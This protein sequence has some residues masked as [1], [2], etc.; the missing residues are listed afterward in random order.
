MV[1]TFGM[2]TTVARAACR[3]ARLH[4]IPDAEIVDGLIDGTLLARIRAM[5]AADHAQIML[6]AKEGPAFRAPK[7]EA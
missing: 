6:I 4:G 5:E 7:G 3:V 2:L 1:R